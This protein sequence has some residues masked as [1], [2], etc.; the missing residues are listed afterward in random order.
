MTKDGK[1]TGR[2]V[3]S[4]RHERHKKMIEIPTRTEIKS[5]E[6]YNIINN[7]NNICE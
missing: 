6:L 2:G 5:K 7:N 4:E 1:P 3:Y